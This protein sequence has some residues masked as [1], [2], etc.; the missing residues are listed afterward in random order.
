MR[1]GVKIAVDL[2]L[3]EGLGPDEKI[4][5]IIRATRYWRAT[6]NVAGDLEH[7]R[8]FAEAE[9]FTERL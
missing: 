7:D 3:P 2:W 5:T 4:P 6:E 1:D 8:N 9:R